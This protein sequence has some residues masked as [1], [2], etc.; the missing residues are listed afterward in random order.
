MTSIM[1]SEALSFL[2]YLIDSQELNIAIEDF[3]KQ[4]KRTQHIKIEDSIK[5][6]L[7][8]LIKELNKQGGLY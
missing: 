6:E 7:T 8:D 1:T 4:Y 3:L 2:N 5:R